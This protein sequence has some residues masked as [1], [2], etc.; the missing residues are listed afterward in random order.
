MGDSLMNDI[1]SSD[2]KFEILEELN[3]VNE[4]NIESE[5]SEK[6]TV[7]NEDPLVYTIDNF[8]SDDEC[9]HFIKLANPHM[10]QAL[11][12]SNEQ[13]QTGIVSTG[14]TGSN[15]WIKHEQ[16]SITASVG[17]R[18]ANYIGVPLNTAEQYQ[19]IHYDV[20]QE[21]RQH[22]DSWE[23][24]GSEKARRCMKYGG[25]RLFTALVYLNDV[26]EGGG[27][28]LTRLKVEI[29]PKKGRLLFFE[30]VHRNT[31]KKQLLSEHAGMPVLKGEKW[32]FNLWFREKP[33]SEI[34][35]DPPVP[36]KVDAYVVDENA[37]GEFNYMD[38]DTTRVL[39]SKFIS[40]E[41]LVSLDEVCRNMTFQQKN[42]N[43]TSR[44]DCWVPTTALGGFVNKIS[45][46]VNID[47][48][49]FENINIVQYSANATH[50]AH[51]DAYDFTRA[52]SELK[53]K[54]RGLTGQRVI[55]ITGSLSD[56]IEYKFPETAQYLQLSRGD[57]LVYKNT[58]RETTSRDI[59]MKKSIDN[60]GNSEGTLFHIYVR[61]KNKE[62]KTIPGIIGLQT[63]NN[64]NT[65]PVKNAHAKF[66]D[67]EDIHD[68][69]IN[70]YSSV[71]EKQRYKSFTFCNKVNWDS[72]LNTVNSLKAVR[73]AQFGIINKDVLANAR[74]FD[75]YTPAIVNNVITKESLKIIQSFIREAIDKNEFTLGDRQSN[76]Y[77]ARDETVT[78]FLHYELVP[79]IRKLTNRP[80]KPTYTYL[81]CYTKDADL[82]AHTD[83]PDCEYTVSFVIDKPENAN[84]PIYFDKTKQPQKNKGR[85]PFTPSKD[86]C[87]PC[88][89]EPGGLM[90]FNG[91][92]HIHYREAC[93]YDY[94]NIVL[95]HYRVI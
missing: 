24:D 34:V 35:Y 62:G 77:K 69:L 46:L 4:G 10:K 43:I 2:I 63:T 1:T 17:E 16:D 11:V 75:E 56:N 26:E 30:N 32:A 74:M 37:V 40:D 79:V 50:C 61:E 52:G 44:Q 78:R 93:E 48:G 14:R 23:H 29:S 92:D 76:R 68:T 60:R 65:E 67:N 53:M 57:L 82:P 21:Y 12:S 28:H 85:Y 81:A 83:Q 15:H 6:K 87:I 27:T 91:T 31:N 19:V 51:F 88:D 3:T 5:E 8:I 9:D 45:K 66:E 13:G 42:K 89:C 49:H 72:V 54:T 80:V 33:R 36:E 38:N 47:Q 86:T 64:V 95:L 25:Q 73:D 20:S 70:A 94:Y 18:I 39:K 55:T 59:K 41:E 7:F 84:W 71:Q 22:H 90:M 58:I